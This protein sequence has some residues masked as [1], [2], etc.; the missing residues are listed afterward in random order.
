LEKLEEEDDDDDDDDDE[1]ED[2]EKAEEAVQNSHNVEQQSSSSLQVGNEVGQIS[3]V[4]RPPTPAFPAKLVHNEVAENSATIQPGSPASC[5]EVAVESDPKLQGESATPALTSASGENG[6]EVVIIPKS[7]EA[8][9]MT[10]ERATQTQPLDFEVK[11]PPKL[12]S[13]FLTPS[14]V[15]GGKRL[16][17]DE[18][19]L[20]S[21]TSAEKV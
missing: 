6:T 8:S 15:A 11:S 5:L 12:M 9:M 18:T 19:V 7:P 17:L 16:K 13:P 21:L 10:I 1:E 2:E 14:K 3:P 4:R 20:K